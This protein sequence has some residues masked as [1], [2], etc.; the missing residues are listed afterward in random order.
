MN[1]GA[2]EVCNSIDDDRDG[3]IDDADASLDT[4][5]ATTWYA[6]LDTD[7]YGDASNSLR[8]CDQP[9]LYE[10]DN[11]DRDDGDRTISPGATEVWYDGI[12]QDCD[13]ADDYDADGDGDPS[14]SYGGTDCD[15]TDSSVY[16]GTGCRPVASCTHPDA[17]T[18]ETY[19]P[20]GIVDI[21]FDDD[22]NAWLPTLISGTDYVYEL[23][24]SG[25]TTVYTGTSNHDIGSIALDPSSSG[26]A[27]GYNNVNYVGYTTSST[28]PVILTSSNITGS[29]WSN[30]YL[31]SSP[32]SIA[33]DSTGC[34]WVPNLSARGTLSCVETDGSSTVV[35]T[36]SS[37]IESVG[38]DSSENLY[39]SVGDTIYSVDQSA[40]TLTAEF[41]ASGTVLDF[42]FDYNDDLYVESNVGE[43]ELAP[44][45]GSGSSTFATVSGQAKLAISPDGYLVRVIPNP[46]SP[47][48][49][50]EFPLPGAQ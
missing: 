27:V 31:N 7:G 23:D 24:A 35:L 6:D 4:S 2:S 29:A 25:N 43:I 5:T 28:I 47:A 3:D 17:S 26:F 45:D 12:D 38:L 40:G 34:I 30:S 41:V 18:L 37:Y 44:A 46:V 11:T 21:V 16:G 9:S 1:P 32:S 8:A 36:A 50:E 22:C 39:V 42:V 33:F 19:D 48:S 14:K 10:T 13:E 15:D 49:Y 20:S